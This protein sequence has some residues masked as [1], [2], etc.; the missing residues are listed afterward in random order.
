MALETQSDWQNQL[1]KQLS[2]QAPYSLVE[3]QLLIDWVNT[4][5]KIR[6]EPGQRIIRPD[7]LPKSLFLILK[8]EIRLLAIGDEREGAFTLCKRGAGQLIGWA[9]LLRAQPTEYIQASTEVI[10]VALSAIDFINLIQKEKSFASHFATL[11]NT[12]ESYQVAVAAAELQPKRPIGWRDDLKTRILQAKAHSLLPGDSLSE[13]PEL[14]EGCSWFLSTANVENTPVGTPLRK[15]SS[16]LPENQQFKL[17]YRII[18][19]P[20]GAIEKEMTIKIWYQ[21]S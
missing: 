9:S 16:Y 17:R 18:G 8:G 4:A 1:L 13:L 5:R 6:F 12:Q 7:E 11:T 3:K 21:K 15:D 2:S 19:L 10:A 14:P 20:N